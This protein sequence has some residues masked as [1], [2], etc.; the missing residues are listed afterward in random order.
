M[1]NGGALKHCKIYRKTFYVIVVSSAIVGHI[2][3]D[4]SYILILIPQREL[5]T[6]NQ[7]CN[8]F[9]GEFRTTT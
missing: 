7:Q 1:S 2:P 9:L 6:L 3:S 8:L 5:V 4:K